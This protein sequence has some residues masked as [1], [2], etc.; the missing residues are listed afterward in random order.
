VSFTIYPCLV[1][2]ESLGS[3]AAR[4]AFPPQEFER[5]ALCGAP[6]RRTSVIGFGVWLA[7]EDWEQRGDDHSPGQHNGKKG[8]FNR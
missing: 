1:E 3:N 6:Y 7:F 8:H 4:A 2:V 5:A